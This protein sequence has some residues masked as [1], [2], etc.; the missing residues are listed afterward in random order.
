MTN[1]DPDIQADTAATSPVAIRTEAGQ[2]V[3]G[4]SGNP[5]GRPKKATLRNLQQDLEIA[6]RDHLSVDRVKR[7]V[8]RMADMAEQGDVKAAKLIFDKLIPN[9]TNGE[10]DEGDN[11]TRVEFKIVNATFAAQTKQEKQVEVIDVT[12]FHVTT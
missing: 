8:N 3:K 12:P 9:A 7:I 4:T 11:V 5:L 2:F 1:A 6:F 10:S